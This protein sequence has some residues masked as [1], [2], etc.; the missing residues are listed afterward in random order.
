M[1]NEQF[2]AA[3]KRLLPHGW[4]YGYLGNVWPDRDDRSWRIFAPHPGRVGRADDCLG[5]FA[6]ENRFELLPL[7]RGVAFAF[8]FLKRETDAVARAEASPASDSPAE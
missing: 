7:A 5:A 2:D 8:A 3:M 4:T 1:T 6:T